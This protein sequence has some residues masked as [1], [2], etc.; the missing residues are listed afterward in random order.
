MAYSLK[1]VMERHKLDTTLRTFTQ[2]LLINP[3]DV[4]RSCAA[5]IAFACANQQGLA[6]E[7]Y[8]IMFASNPALAD[9]QLYNYAGMVGLDVESFPELPEN[10]KSMNSSVTCNKALSWAYKQHRL[11]H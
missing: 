8:D 6:W 3:A 9:E 10:P 5:A 11:G 2:R 4:N 1:M 7:M